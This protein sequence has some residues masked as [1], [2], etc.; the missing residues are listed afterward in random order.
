MIIKLKN[1]KKIIFAS[2]LLVTLVANANTPVDS[3]PTPR[4]RV[5][6]TYDHKVW[7]LDTVYAYDFNGDMHLTT[8]LK[9]IK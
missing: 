9:K 7:K 2:L 5:K 6:T 3:L 4:K 8:I 1:M